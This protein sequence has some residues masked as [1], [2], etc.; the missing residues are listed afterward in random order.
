MSKLDEPILYLESKIINLE[1]ELDFLIKHYISSLYVVDDIKQKEI[2]E[3]KRRIDAFRE[4]QKDVI[5]AKTIDNRQI[6][7]TID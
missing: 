7:D 4:A 6:K 5:H 1:S 3:L 2:D